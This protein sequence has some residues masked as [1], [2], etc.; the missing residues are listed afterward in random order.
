MSLVI[1]NV[2]SFIIVIEQRKL[3]YFSSLFL[4]QRHQVRS[5]NLRKAQ[6]FK[7]GSTP[8]LKHILSFKRVQNIFRLSIL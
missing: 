2:Y 8:M 7:C 6:G 5:Q 1:S 3:S 4:P